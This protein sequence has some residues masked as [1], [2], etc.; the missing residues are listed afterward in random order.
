MM[1]AKRKKEVVSCRIFKRDLGVVVVTCRIKPD[2]ISSPPP[3]S[4]FRDLLL[5][6]DGDC[7]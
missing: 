5:S 2:S 1:L 4:E 7:T 3:H 6:M